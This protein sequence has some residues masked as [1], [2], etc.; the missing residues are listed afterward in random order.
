[1]MINEALDHLGLKLI[2]SEKIPANVYER[3]IHI[4]RLGFDPKVIFDCGAFVGKWTL[5]VSQIFPKAFFV[6]IEPNENIINRTKATVE[7][8]HSR[9]LV[10]TV[11]VGEKI[12]KRYL[13]IWEDPN[14]KKPIVS[15]EGASLLSHV[16]GKPTSRISVK[17]KTIDSI[18][19]S[20]NLTPDLIKLDLQ[21]NEIAALIGAKSLFGRT[22]VFI[23]EFGCLD[24]YINRTT[25]RDLITIMYDN[26]YCLYDIVDL[27]YRPYDKALA[28]GD[29]FFIKKNSLLRNHLDFF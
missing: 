16:R 23:I 11:A 17:I 26:N 6:L 14:L 4:K 12:G 20:Y 2:K 25:P 21:G 28:G 10:L 9:N 24:A 8:I 15:L 5:R 27:I 18:A 1:M 19:S 22:E 3:L 13:N 29:F 7:S